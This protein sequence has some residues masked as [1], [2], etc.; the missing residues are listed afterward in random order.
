MIIF[1]GSVFKP[2]LSYRK[3]VRQLAMNLTFKSRDAFIGR[4]LKM[5]SELAVWKAEFSLIS[6]TLEKLSAVIQ[7]SSV[8]ISPV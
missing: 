1:L 2:L 8:N 6:L 7:A 5:I 3:S 4:K